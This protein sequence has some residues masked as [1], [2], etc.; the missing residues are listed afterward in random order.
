MYRS[1]LNCDDLARIL[2][3]KGKTENGVCQ[4]SVERKDIRATIGNM[5]FHSLSHM[6][7]FQP[8]DANGNSLITCELVLLENEVD[9][10][11]SGITSAGIIV[12]AI[13][14]HWLFDE[15]RLMY[16]HA[17]A[18]MAPAV[19]AEAMARVLSK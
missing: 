10:I 6:F 12:S 14:S 15:P 7:D 3:G 13:H 4:V 1:D 16:I 18:I 2:G 5:P 9:R 11:N 8:A 19:F 17:E